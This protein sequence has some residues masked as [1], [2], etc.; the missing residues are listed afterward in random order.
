M[1]CSPMTIVPR[2]KHSSET[3]TAERP[4]TRPLNADALDSHGVVQNVLIA[5][6]ADDKAP[7]RTGLPSA[8]RCRSG[9]SSS[10]RTIVTVP[11]WLYPH[12]CVLMF[13]SRP[14]GACGSKHTNSGNAAGRQHSAVTGGTCAGQSRFHAVLL[15]LIAEATASTRPDCSTPLSSGRTNCKASSVSALT[16]WSSSSSVLL[17]VPGPGLLA[18]ATRSRMGGPTRRS[19]R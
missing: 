16:T 12:S 18:A 5:Y 9:G 13:V 7:S 2:N 15:E 14:S 4:S 17:S 10:P 1:F 19:R 11:T 3:T 6:R 8:P